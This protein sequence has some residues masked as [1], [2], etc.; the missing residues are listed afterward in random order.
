VGLESL[1]FKEFIKGLFIFRILYFLIKNLW[2]FIIIFIFWP[3]INAIFAPYHWWQ[4]LTASVGKYIL[5]ASQAI[6]N[7]PLFGTV[8]SVID[9]WADEIRIRLISA[10]QSH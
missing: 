4:V 8:L 9:R 1:S 2:P 10:L 6:R 3:E 5:V 7:I